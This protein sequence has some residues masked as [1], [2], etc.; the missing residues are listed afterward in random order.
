MSAF[1]R[2]FANPCDPR[3]GKCWWERN[4]PNFDLLDPWVPGTCRFTDIDAIVHVESAINGD[5]YLIL[6]FK[7]YDRKDEG[8]ERLLRAMAKS[9]NI[10]C[11]VITG[12]VNPLRPRKATVF[13]PSRED[14]EIDLPGLRTWL[15]KWGLERAPDRVTGEMPDPRQGLTG[16]L[17]G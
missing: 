15:W 10:V 17:F 11:M 8:Q 9:P 5:Q 2:N 14:L 1:S 4:K 7:R 3:S 13:R 16:D 6:E 12:Q